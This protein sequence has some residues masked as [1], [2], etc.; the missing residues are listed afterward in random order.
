MQIDYVKISYKDNVQIC[1]T[2]FAKKM[3][4]NLHK[5]TSRLTHAFESKDEIW[6]MYGQLGLKEFFKRWKSPKRTP[7]FH[8]FWNEE[9]HSEK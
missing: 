3:E 2:K 9:L 1:R 7:N 5:T 6:A 4:R 8:E